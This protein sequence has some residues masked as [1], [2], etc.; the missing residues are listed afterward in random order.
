MK[1]NI[2]IQGDVKTIL[3]TLDKESIDCVVTSPPYW[4]LRDYGTAT[5]EGGNPKCDHK[6]AKEKS[7]YDYD[8]SKAQTG[9]H[10]G[11]K[12]GTDQAK[13]KNICPA[14][15]AIKKDFQLGLEQ[16]F[17]EYIIK[18]CDI[19]DEVKKVLKKSGTCFINM[20]DTYG[21]SNTGHC[22][23]APTKWKSLPRS[24]GKS[25]QSTLQSKCLLQIPAR[26]SIEMC[27]RGWILR[28]TIV[29]H[30]PN[31]MPSSV[32]DRFTVDFEYI[33]FFVKSKKYWFE[34]QIEEYTEA[35]NRWGGDTLKR[36]TSKTQAY[37][38]QQNIGNSSA[39]RAGR[40]MRPDDRGRNKRCVW[41]I[42][43]KPYK[44]AHFAV[45][46]EELVET[47]IKSGGPEGGIVL[48]PFM[49]SGT[50]AVVAKRLNRNWL[51]IELNPKYI[52]MANKRIANT[53]GK[54]L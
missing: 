1:T 36:E 21:G 46:P 11:A 18:L 47:P 3:K 12:K 25:R 31:V 10:G 49:G 24:E 5:W 50:V 44:E 28:N 9:T 37:F 40:P 13:W 45:F 23:P 39:L 32:K 38:K 52:K 54:L 16:T 15:G 43:T 26:F 35:L 29:W 34:R 48:D 27:N 4:A 51:G 14:C 6:T 8:L 41:R 7:R 22:G 2:I 17:Q 30:K 42:T 19:F 20:G 33:F 53:M